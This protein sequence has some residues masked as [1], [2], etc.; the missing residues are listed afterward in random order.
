[1]LRNAPRKKSTQCNI[2]HEYLVGIKLIKLKVSGD[3]GSQSNAYIFEKVTNNKY[4][5]YIIAYQ[6]QLNKIQKLRLDCIL[7]KFQHLLKASAF[8]EKR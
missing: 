6:K 7:K 5:F 2:F 1:M 8:L 3:T 4:E